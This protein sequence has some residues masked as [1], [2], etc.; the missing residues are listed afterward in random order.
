MFMDVYGDW[1]GPSSDILLI[2]SNRLENASESSEVGSSGVNLSGFGD[3]ETTSHG[4]IQSHR[5]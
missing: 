3:G 5:R 4:W 2:S 1:D